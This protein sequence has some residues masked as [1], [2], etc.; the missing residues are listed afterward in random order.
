MRIK[1]ELLLMMEKV[2]RRVMIYRN[3][4][5]KDSSILDID[6]EKLAGDVN[7]DQFMIWWKEEIFKKVEMERLFVN[8]N[9]F[10][11]DKGAWKSLLEKKI[12]LKLF[13][14]FIKMRKSERKKIEKKEESIWI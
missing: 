7:L 3:M 14:N 13:N 1:N 9:F 12:T 5:D 2:K 6:Q 4:Q 11:F 8:D 10:I